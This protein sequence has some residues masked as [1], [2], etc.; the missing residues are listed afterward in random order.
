MAQEDKGSDSTAHDSGVRKGEELSGDEADLVET[1]TD[2][3]D[4]PTGTR[5]ARISTSINPEDEEPIDPNMPNMP[6]A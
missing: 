1:G 2:E 3:A 5:T 6:P 4:R